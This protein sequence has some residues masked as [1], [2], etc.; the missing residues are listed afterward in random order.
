VII[1]VL[2][3]G[4]VQADALS[5]GYVAFSVLFWYMDEFVSREG[6]RVWRLDLCLNFLQTTIQ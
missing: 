2:V 1:I 6:N 4:T 3:M 5:F